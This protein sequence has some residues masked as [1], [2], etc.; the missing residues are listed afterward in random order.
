MAAAPRSG[1]A[2]SIKRTCCGKLRWQSA[3]NVTPL[4]DEIGEGTLGNIPYI[5]SATIPS[6]TMI[7]VDAAD[8]VV[9]GGGAPRMEMSDQAPRLHM[10]DG[11]ASKW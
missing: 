2:S 3:P 5:D 9:I 6:K 10:E 8:F 1:V 4:W 7:L 11:Y